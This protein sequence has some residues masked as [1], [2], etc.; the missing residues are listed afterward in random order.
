MNTSP[1]YQSRRQVGCPEASKNYSSRSPSRS[2]AASVDP[3]RSLASGATFKSPYRK[4]EL[5]DQGS[6]S[7][8]RP[9]PIPQ[10][11]ATPFR[12]IP[13]T[14]PYYTTQSASTNR[15]S[16]FSASRSHPSDN[17]PRSSSL[18]RLAFS[19]SPISPGQYLTHYPSTVHSTKYVYPPTSSYSSSALPRRDPLHS[20][21]S[22][23]DLPENF[24]Y[25]SIRSPTT[26]DRPSS[27][28]YSSSSYVNVD[29]NRKI[30]GHYESRI[31]FRPQRHHQQELAEVYEF[32]TSPRPKPRSHP[33]GIDSPDSANPYSSSPQGRRDSSPPT[34]EVNVNNTYSPLTSTS[35]S[36]STNEYPG[37]PAALRLHG[38]QSG[39]NSAI[40]S[41]SRSGSS[42]NA[43]LIGLVNLGNTCFMNCILQCLSNTNA[44]RLLCLN[45]A[46]TP[47]LNVNST[48]KGNLFKAYAELMRQMWSP[49]NNGTS[50]INPHRFRSQIQRFAP[51]FVGNAQ[52]DA[53][54]FLRY[55]VQG[56]HED[57]NRVIHRPPIEV[58]NYDKEDKM[59]D[60]KKAE[61]Y[62]QRYKRLDDSPIADLF[63]GQLMSTLECLECGHKSTTFDP[64]WDLSLPIPPMSKVDIEDCFNHFTSNEILGGSDQPGSGSLLTRPHKCVHVSNVFTCGQVNLDPLQLGSS[65]YYRFISRTMCSGCK[66]RQPCRKRFSI[67]RFPKIL[68]IHFKRFS[69]DRSGSKIS[70]FIDYPIEDLD[71]TQ[72]ASCCSSETDAR[73]KLY[74][75]SNH[76][77]DVFLGHY[78]ACCRHPL[79]KS[80]FLFNDQNVRKIEP[81]D[82]ISAQAY[83]L[84]YQRVH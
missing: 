3:Y 40:S 27:R 45:D 68:V 9:P 20:K 69:G 11:Q 62:W 44:L 79:L 23:Y 60:A 61:L 14:R 38:G 70:T 8:S 42:M 59:P 37:S 36:S 10:R 6:F 35:S 2:R 67:H 49:T 78:T 32:K 48:M 73:Y 55:L 39:I 77:G 74:A 51:R 65:A 83:V 43:G 82:A 57:V 71:L 76:N 41:A 84:F 4:Y 25:L 34:P 46:D 81:R 22:N 18:S 1:A 75:L 80:W 5:S 47:E 16:A 30:N 12:V 63:M 13:S 56:L 54:E 52:Q 58:P 7:R 28:N 53:Q 72:Y 19:D 31:E 24:P 50:Y 21:R 29:N 26:Y 64:F 33:R 66:L 15:S 17:L